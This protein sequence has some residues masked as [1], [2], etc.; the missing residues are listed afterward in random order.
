MLGSIPRDEKCQH[1]GKSKVR[2]NQCHYTTFVWWKFLWDL[3]HLPLVFTI[4]ILMVVDYVL[5]WV[6]AIPCKANNHNKAM[7]ENIY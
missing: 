2:D 7:K 1:L 6:D 4:Y 5:K 3:F